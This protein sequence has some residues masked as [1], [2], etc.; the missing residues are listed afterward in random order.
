[1]YPNDIQLILKIAFVYQVSFKFSKAIDAYN[2]VIQ[3]DPTS[4]EAW[5]GLALVYKFLGK[6]NESK[7]ALK[8]IKVIKLDHKKKKKNA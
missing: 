8:R 5:E 1:M 3:I 6:R 4:L 7:K 2:Q